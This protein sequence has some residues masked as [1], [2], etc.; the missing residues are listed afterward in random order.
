MQFSVTQHIGVNSTGRFYSQ[1]G[2]KTGQLQC[3]RPHTIKATEFSNITTSWS[4]TFGDTKIWSSLIPTYLLLLSNNRSMINV[5]QALSLFRLS[6]ASG[7]TARH[8]VSTSRASRHTTMSSG[9][10]TF[11]GS[12]VIGDPVCSTALWI[13]SLDRWTRSR[14]PTLADQAIFWMAFTV[15]MSGDT[16]RIWKIKRSRGNET[17]Q[18]AA[19]LP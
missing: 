6:R 1:G 14:D 9:S 11:S 4:V 15:I 3:L 17:K 10:I 19:I 8:T 16:F 18:L 7:H 5:C 12:G 2:L 13:S